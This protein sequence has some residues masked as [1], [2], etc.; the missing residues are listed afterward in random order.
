MLGLLVWALRVCVQ[1]S[2]GLGVAVTSFS[3]A[4]PAIALGTLWMMGKTGVT[5]EVM[6]GGMSGYWVILIPA[7]FAAAC[8][9]LLISTVVHSEKGVIIWAVVYAIVQVVFSAFVP[10]YVTFDQEKG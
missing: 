4:F 5:Q 9:G 2:G 6:E 7:F 8:C 3:I 1:L 10:L